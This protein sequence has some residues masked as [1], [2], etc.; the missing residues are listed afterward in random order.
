[1]SKISWKH[2]STLKD[3]FFKVETIAAGITQLCFRERQLGN[4]VTSV[5]TKDAGAGEWMRIK[6]IRMF[7]FG[8]PE[9]IRSRMARGV[10][11]SFAGAV[12]SQAFSL[13]AQVIAAHVL[14]K[15]G[16]GRLGIVNN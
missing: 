15:T 3:P 13:V 4:V 9:T 14:G 8:G 10:L 12:A 5:V 7:A 1:M 11:W 6:V 16:F 2:W